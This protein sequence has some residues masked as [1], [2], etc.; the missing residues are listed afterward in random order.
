MSQPIS[1]VTPGPYLMLDVSIE[2]A[3]SSFIF[4]ASRL[5]FWFYFKLRNMFNPDLVINHQEIA[6]SH[7]WRMIA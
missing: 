3:V 4:F 7:Y 2:K 1:R 5:L 6:A